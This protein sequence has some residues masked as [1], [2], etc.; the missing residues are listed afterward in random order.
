MDSINYISIDDLR[1]NLYREED[2]LLLDCRSNDEYRN[3]HIGGSHNIVLPQLM[4][5]RLKANKLSLKS[6]VPPNF[7]QEKEAFLKKCM[8]YQVVLYDSFTTDLNNNDT[9][10]LGLLYNRMK[11]ENCTVV[12]LKGESRYQH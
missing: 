2:V 11:N 5:R 7:R 1:D 12:V 6:L 8:T 3:G 9:S 10:M 4:M